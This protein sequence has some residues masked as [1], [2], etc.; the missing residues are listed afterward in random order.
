MEVVLNFLNSFV[1]VQKFGINF[2]TLSFLG[3]IVF[4]LFQ[5]I[6]IFRQ[7]RVV[8][9]KKNG[10][11]VS[12]L[13]FGY[14]AGYLFALFPYGIMQGSL[15]L[16][17]NS[18][19]GIFC[20]YVTLGLWNYKKC[21]PKYEWALVFL[22]LMLTAFMFALSAAGKEI[23]FSGL[24]FGILLFSA[25]QLFE[26]TKKKD[27]GNVSIGVQ[28][29]FMASNVFWFFYSL[30]IGNVPLAIFNPL[31]FV[32]NWQIIRSARKYSRAA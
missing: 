26:I 17:F 4:T 11:S 19:L 6:S 1:E 25:H 30:L 3:T 18:L 24:L 29:A 15:A 22:F 8:W 13:Q 7:G 27:A 16:I 9:G 2:L 10:E 28:K 12:V 32:I 14:F 23:L 21:V 5:M 20:F 31:A